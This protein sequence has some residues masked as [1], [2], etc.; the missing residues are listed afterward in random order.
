MLTEVVCDKRSRTSKCCLF[1]LYTLHNT[2]EVRKYVNFYFSFFEL[3]MI[4]HNEFLNRLVFN[5]S[6]ENKSEILNSLPFS[7]CYPKRRYMKLEDA[8]F[9][10]GFICKPYISE[11]EFLFSKMCLSLPNIDYNSFILRWMSAV[12]SFVD[13][14][15]LS[16]SKFH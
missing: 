9:F 14:Y 10:H 3:I 7:L 4:E 2:I 16:I 5:H 12:C 1:S 11:R 8:E 6:P 13:S 15:C